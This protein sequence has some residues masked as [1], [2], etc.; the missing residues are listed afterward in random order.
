MLFHSF[1]FMSLLII[2]FSLYY[3]FPRKRLG[4]LAVANLVFYSVSGIGYLLI[5]LGVSAITYY[6]SIKLKAAH[7]K[8]F[9]SFG[10]FVNFAN[11][12]FFK[13]TGFILKN[14][15]A[16]LGVHFPW[17]DTL[18]AKIILPVGI[19]FYTF[20]LV[21][22]L[23]DVKRE[24]IVPCESFVKFW[25]FIS[26]FAQLIAGPIMRGKEF[27]PQ[28]TL[29]NKIKY[30][31]DN[32]RIGLSY[33]AMGLAKKLMFS[34]ILSP[35]VEY[36]F[37]QANQLGTLDAWFAAYLFAFQIYFDFSSYSEIAVGVGKLF[38]F[39]MTINFRTP[40][41]SGSPSEFWKRWHITLSS[42]IKDYL[43]IPMGG[44]KR[45]FP[46]QCLFLLIAMTLSGL[47]HGAAWSFIIWGIYHGLLSVLH[48]LYA[49]W[50]HHR[51]PPFVHH[52]WYTWATIFM[53]FQLTTIGWVFF[54][55]E[56]LSHALHMVKVMLTF[57]HFSFSSVYLLYFGFIGCLWLLHLVEYQVRKN[58][59]S[60]MAIWRTYFPDY[61]RA[62][63]YVIVFLILIM[64]T[65]GE[66]STFIY[67][68]F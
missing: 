10:I 55:A 28:I 21:A 9:Y 1:E 38:G 33:I 29:L 4:L 37:A 50:K 66:Q 64:F 60:L 2:T 44:S 51:N 32:I 14:V 12:A 7:G 43:Y 22:Y 48:K 63:A 23:V 61:V 45:G 58:A 24:E 30:K 16:A 56:N 17:Q 41:L 68:Q 49:R 40:Y 47:W 34:D 35:R 54:R 19:S 5:F 20:Q 31:E 52:R 6:C 26:F 15:E 3:L 62:A 25:V 59:L 11:L 18:L 39:D 46:L 67:F 36:Y 57:S 42:W 13:Y 53:F 65:Q 8:L 27:L